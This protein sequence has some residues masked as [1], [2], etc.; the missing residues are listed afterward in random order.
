MVAHHTANPASNPFVGV[1]GDDEIWAYGLAKS[2][3][4]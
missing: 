1:T 2:L 4:L 3:A